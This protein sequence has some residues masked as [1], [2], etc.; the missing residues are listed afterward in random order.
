[1]ISG[2]PGVISCLICLLPL[3]SPLF[4]GGFKL[5]IPFFENLFSLAVQL[6]CWGDVADGAVKSNGVVVFDILCH[7]SPGVVK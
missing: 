5:L 4:P 6:V 1:M 2:Y 3:D 7:K